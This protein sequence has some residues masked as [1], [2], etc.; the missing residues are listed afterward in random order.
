MR[1]SWPSFSKTWKTSES[2]GQNWGR[3]RLNVEWL[4]N[5]MF[6]SCSADMNIH[7]M[8]VKETKPIKT[9]TYVSMYKFLAAK[10]A[11]CT[12]G[13]LWACDT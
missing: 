8:D 1:I 13:L 9:L 3:L 11:V 6:A 12:D 5:T 2:T 4:D 7:I 10:I